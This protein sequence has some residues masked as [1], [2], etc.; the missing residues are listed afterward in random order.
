MAETLSPRVPTPL[1]AQHWGPP[2]KSETNQ[3]RSVSQDSTCETHTVRTGRF[4]GFANTMTPPTSRASL[5]KKGQMPSSAIRNEASC[6]AGHVRWGG[7]SMDSLLG[8]SYLQDR[9]VSAPT[10]AFRWRP[11]P[12]LSH[13]NGRRGRFSHSPDLQR[14]THVSGW[15]YR[16]KFHL[17][18]LTSRGCWHAMVSKW[19]V[20]GPEGR[21]RA[22]L[23]RRRTSMIDGERASTLVP[24][25][26]GVSQ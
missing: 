2:G 9:R 13:G 8:G 21:L 23:H 14:S 4:L 12:A 5:N 20:H 10:T 26:C 6:G 24:R 7:K 1:I 11:P 3:R 17:G 18:L 25:L 22:H 16:T 19:R 15:T